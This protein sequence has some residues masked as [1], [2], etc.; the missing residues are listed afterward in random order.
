MT[1]NNYICWNKGAKKLIVLVAE[2]DIEKIKNGFKLFEGMQKDNL[3]Y[4]YRG[5]FTQGITDS[6]ISL[7][8][9]NLDSSGESNKVK[10]RVFSI[11]VECL[12]NVTRHQTS[13]GLDEIEPEQAGVVVIQNENDAYQITSGNVVEKKAIPHLVGM[14]EKIN[15][16]EKDELKLYYKEVLEDGI[17][18]DKGGAGLGLIEMA[19]RSGN[20]LFFDFTEIDENVSYFYLHTAISKESDGQI[21]YVDFH[22]IKE[23]HNI[24]NEENIML[25]F[26]GTLNQDGLIHLLS[27]LENQSIGAIDIRKKLFNIMVEMLQN[28]IKHGEKK[29]DEM[30]GNPGIFYLS[31]NDGTYILSTGNYIKNTIVEELANKMEHVNS[32]EKDDLDMFYTRRL[33][34]FDIDN[35]KEAGLGIID[36]RIKSGNKLQYSFSEVNDKISFFSFQVKIKDGSTNN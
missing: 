14:L 7:A 34:N 36:L 32:L 28:I 8:E 29:D 4:L 2:Q 3:G 11:L 17:I 25:I 10:K 12:Q 27:I 15:S 31:E 22:N 26:N 13:E 30:G 6:I 18:S 21:E 33:L 23:L 5:L 1:I 24:V 20:K 19:R 35:S 16:L 9:N